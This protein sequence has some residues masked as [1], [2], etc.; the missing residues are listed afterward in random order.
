MPKI[1]KKIPTGL[2]LF[3]QTLLLAIPLWLSPA[4]AQGEARLVVRLHPI[5]STWSWTQFGGKCQETFQYRADN[6]MISTSGGAVTE[7]TYRITPQPDAKGFY[8]LVETSSRFNSKK[9]C[10]GD[11]LDQTG[12]ETTRFIQMSPTRDRFLACTTASLDACF[13]PLGRIK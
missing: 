13:G 5:V 11:L 10:S 4:H 12:L 9:D 7:G 3:V 6:T 1:S 2:A 8:T